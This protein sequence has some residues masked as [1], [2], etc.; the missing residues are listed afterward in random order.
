MHVYMYLCI[1]LL[2]VSMYALIHALPYLTVSSM[3][4]THTWWLWVTCFLLSLESSISLARTRVRYVVHMQVLNQIRSLH[5]QFPILQYQCIRSLLIPYLN[6]VAE[7]R[8]ISLEQF[9]TD[10]LAISAAT[11]DSKYIY[12][13]LHT[14]ER[15]V[16][17]AHMRL[18]VRI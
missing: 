11:V 2:L 10:V 13:F 9:L 12:T 6:Q 5:T 14:T 8:K 3:S 7:K 16:H 18:K 17:D 15:D 4:C 1:Y